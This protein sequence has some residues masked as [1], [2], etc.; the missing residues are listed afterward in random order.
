MGTAVVAVAICACVCIFLTRFF[1]M[2]TIRLI[3][4]LG[5]T[6]CVAHWAVSNPKSASSIVDN[7][8]AAI[9]WMS[10]LVSENLFDSKEGA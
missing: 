6:Y 10:D 7:V 8:D 9:I 5:L 1:I 4:A 2:N 3:L